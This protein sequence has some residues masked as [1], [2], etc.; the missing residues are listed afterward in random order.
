MQKVPALLRPRHSKTE[1][2]PEA[3]QKRINDCISC[4]NDKQRV[5]YNYTADDRLCGAE[6][7]NCSSTC[8]SE[9]ASSSSSGSECWSQSDK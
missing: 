9:G 5:C 1:E 8:N 3:R 6:S 4:C 7:Q 2:T